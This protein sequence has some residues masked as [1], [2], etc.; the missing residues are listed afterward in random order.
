MP[1]DSDPVWLHIDR[2]IKPSPP[3]PPRREAVKPTRSGAKLLRFF[4]W[5]LRLSTTL[6]RCIR[7]PSCHEGPALSGKPGPVATV[8]GV[9]ASGGRTTRPKASNA[10]K[11]KSGSD[12]YGM[13]N[14]AVS[15]RCST[16]IQNTRAANAVCLQLL[17]GARLGKVLSS[18]KEDFYLHRGTWTKPLASDQTETNRVFTPQCPGSDACN[19][20]N[21]D[22]RGG[23]PFSRQ[24]AGRH[25][26]MVRP[27]GVEVLPDRRRPAGGVS[28]VMPSICM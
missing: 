11:N 16:N 10:I 22:Q 25:M 5:R 24:Q 3:Q 6:E 12:V 1:L 28:S 7:D 26:A 9:Q 21:R 23:L 19:V 17:T 13:R 15:V 18:R 8:Q 27:P 14:F 20:D 2:E 4:C